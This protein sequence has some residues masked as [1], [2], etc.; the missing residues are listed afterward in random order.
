MTALQQLRVEE[1]V[2]A[3]QKS[4]CESEINKE[5]TV[6]EW[7]VRD[8]TSTDLCFLTIEKRAKPNTGHL[9]MLD[10]MYSICLGKN[11]GVRSAKLITGD[12][13]P[14]MTARYVRRGIFA[15]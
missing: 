10:K 2:S 1:I 9:F 15:L 13:H 4:F 3:A 7:D 14:N 8:S 5:S 6:F 12:E 11:G